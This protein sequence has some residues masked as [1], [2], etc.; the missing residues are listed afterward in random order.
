MSLTFRGL[1][2]NFSKKQRN[3]NK[4]NSRWWL[5]RNGSSPTVLVSTVKFL[6]FF[7]TH[8]VSFLGNKLVMPKD[9]T[10]FAFD[11][12]ILVIKTVGRGLLSIRSSTVSSIGLE[13]HELRWR[14]LSS[15]I[16]NRHTQRIQEQIT[17]AGSSPP[18]LCLSALL[19]LFPSNLNSEFACFASIIGLEKVATKP[20][21]LVVDGDWPFVHTALH[22]LRSQQLQTAHTDSSAYMVLD[23]GLLCKSV[24]SHLRSN[25]TSIFRF[26]RWHWINMNQGNDLWI[27]ISIKQRFLYFSCFRNEHRY[28]E[29]SQPVHVNRWI[30]KL[31][32]PIISQLKN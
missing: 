11:G 23:Y 25:E 16:H 6:W 17:S 3:K 18:C 15:L 26:R 22:T 20:I 30:E 2:F 14:L 9:D 19:R 8:I 32:Q 13:I 10:W 7:R 27:R 4:T 29:Y 24:W 28:K 1:S 5:P 31:L 21:L 12:F